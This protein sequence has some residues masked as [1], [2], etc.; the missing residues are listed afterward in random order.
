MRRL[1]GELRDDYDTVLIDTGPILGSLE[2][3]IICAL[4]DRSILTVARGKSPKLVQSSLAR[5]KHLG[6]RSIGIVFNR[7]STSDITK[8]ISHVSIHS[9]SVRALPSGDAARRRTPTTPLAL[10]VGDKG[11]DEERSAE[12]PKSQRW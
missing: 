11:R 6:A 4:A 2:A 3:D 1:I 8:S 7:A 5:L 9:E 10:A 12:E